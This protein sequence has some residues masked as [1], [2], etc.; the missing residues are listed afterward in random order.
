MRATRIVLLIANGVWLPL[1]AYGG[2]SHVYY[3]ATY[4][5]THDLIFASVLLTTIIPTV[6][7]SS[8]L[9]G[10]IAYIW[11]S[12]PHA[13][14]R[15][16][17]LIA[18]G[19]WLLLHAVGGPLQVYV[20]AANDYGVAEAIATCVVCFSI[21]AGNITYIWRSQPHALNENGGRRI[22]HAP[23][24]HEYAKSVG[25]GAP[26][27]IGERMLR[28][29]VPYLLCTLLFVFAG[30]LVA[31]QLGSQDKS[32]A[33]T[34]YNRGVAYHAKGDTDR[35][36]AHYNE[37]IRL[38]PGLAEAYSSRGIA[39]RARGDTDRAIA[40]YNEGH[41][42]RS[43]LRRC[44]QQSRLGLLQGGQRRAGPAGRRAVAAT[45]PQRCSLAGHARPHLRGARPARGG[46]HRL[47]Q[48]AVDKP[49]T[50]SQQGGIEA[51]RRVARLSEPAPPVAQR[52]AKI[53][54][55]KD[56]NPRTIILGQ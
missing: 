36:I 16:V 25:D 8:T 40:D 2:A 33:Q 45:A 4:P 35:A 37:A 27:L 7:A 20:L 43:E 17:L 46:H 19:V 49:E 32:R 39:Y 3:V 29:P 50:R 47:P 21:L 52:Q 26:A 9:A 11:R 55:A 1:Y 13:A 23:A 18:N 54:S 6:V 28:A 44:L 22:A 31:A 41:Q 38:D 14:V 56:N 30:L 5:T 10:N 42:A 12:R 24:H 34:Y 48:G 53:V 15:I 51:A